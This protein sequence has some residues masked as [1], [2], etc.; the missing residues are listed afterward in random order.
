MI[1][2]EDNIL[3]VRS[4][5]LEKDWLVLVSKQEI[6]VMELF[7]PHGLSLKASIS[8]DEIEEEV[9][10]MEV[11]VRKVP[12]GKAAAA[13]AQTTYIEIVILHD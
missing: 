1:T 5:P 10:Q 9:H 6:A 11:S 8:H 2:F 4:V 3:A 12:S 7:K 13:S